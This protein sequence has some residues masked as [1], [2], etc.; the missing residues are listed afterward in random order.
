MRCVCPPIKPLKLPIVEVEAICPP[1]HIPP[2]LPLLKSWE[3]MFSFPE[4]VDITPFTFEATGLF[5]VK[6][7]CLQSIASTFVATDRTPT[8]DQLD[9]STI[10]LPIAG[11]GGSMTGEVLLFGDGFDYTANLTPLLLEDGRKV[12]L[13]T[14]FIDTTVAAENPIQLIFVARLFYCICPKKKKCC[15]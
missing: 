11:Q 2:A 10:R 13:I 12:T 5:N 9:Q 14:N 15:H 4:G 6:K 8:K 7:C 3:I 1:E